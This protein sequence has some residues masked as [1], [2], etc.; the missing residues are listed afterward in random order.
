VVALLQASDG[1]AAALGT[2]NQEHL[3]TAMLGPG[4]YQI[5]GVLF[6]AALAYLLLRTGQRN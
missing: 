4:G 2:V 6:F 3:V 1:T 5:L